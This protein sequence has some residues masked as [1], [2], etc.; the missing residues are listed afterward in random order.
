MFSRTFPMTHTRAGKPTWFVEKI[1]KCLWETTSFQGIA[2][3]EAAYQETFPVGEAPEENIHC[4]FPKGHTIRAG[5]RWK[6]GDFFAPRIWSGRPYNSKTIQFAPPIMVENIW[7]FSIINRTIY[8]DAAAV[9]TDTI[10]RVAKNDGLAF[11]DF[12]TWFMPVSKKQ[13][14]DFEGQIICWNKNIEY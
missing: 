2:E 12:L 3:Y 7:R 14:P 10:E 9:H 11:D 6:I 1:W 13:Q 4:H 8:I 5:N